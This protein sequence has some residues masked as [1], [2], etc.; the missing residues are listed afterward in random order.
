M[1]GLSP[2]NASWGVFSCFSGRND[3]RFP[4]LRG[5]SRLRDL[6]ARQSRWDVLAEIEDLIQAGH[7]ERAPDLWV[8]AANDQL[9][10]GGVGRLA[11][12][13]KPGNVGGVDEPYARQIQD[14]V[15]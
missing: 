12:G 11:E 10:T 7:Q 3:E 6:K 15:D 2:F 5:S 14:R 8:D 13:E 4:T 1:R 9:G